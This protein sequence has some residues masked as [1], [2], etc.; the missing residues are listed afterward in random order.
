MVK[1]CLSLL[2]D[3]T[4]AL[5]WGSR[6]RPHP[7]RF[8]KIAGIALFFFT[9]MKKE[10]NFLKKIFF[11]LLCNFYKAGGVLWEIFVQNDGKS[12]AVAN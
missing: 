7:H 5:C 11:F 4:F 6:I 1:L 8:G 10:K 9:D 2:L 12:F 3:K